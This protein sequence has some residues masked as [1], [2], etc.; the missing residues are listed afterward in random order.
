MVHSG[1]GDRI[2]SGTFQVK[3]PGARS[4]DSP[5]ASHSAV[6]YERGEG[7][8]DY[9]L[10]G[11]ESYDS[12]EL[13]RLSAFQQVTTTVPPSFDGRSSWFAYEDAID[14]C[15]DIA[16]LGNEKRRPALRNRLESEAAIH[17]RLVD[18]DRLK[19]PNNGATYFKSFLRPLLVKGQCIPVPLPAVH[20]PASRH[21]RHA[22][23]DYQVPPL[24]AEDARS[25]ERHLPSQYGSEQC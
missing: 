3:T 11:N 2:V 21:W 16:E 9:L 4:V 5:M 15:C 17:K 1:E 7:D 25:L 20:E 22:S 6:P 23:L 24:C 19:D 8:D 18:R 13:H 14:D 12:Q 10:Q